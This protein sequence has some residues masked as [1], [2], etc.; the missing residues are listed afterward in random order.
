ME[1]KTALV[2]VHAS[3]PHQGF[4]YKNGTV[5][6]ENELT[7]WVK[8]FNG[9]IIKRHKRRHGVVINEQIDTITQKTGS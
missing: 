7:V 8:L 4:Q 6:K 5:V 2:G 9:K 1:A 3:Y